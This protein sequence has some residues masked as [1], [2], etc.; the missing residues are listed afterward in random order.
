M[1][2]IK[3]ENKKALRSYLQMF[4]HQ[5]G[6]QKLHFGLPQLALDRGWA[7]YNPKEQCCDGG[8]ALPLDWNSLYSQLNLLDL[9]QAL[10]PLIYLPSSQGTLYHH[11]FSGHRQVC[12]SFWIFFQESLALPWFVTGLPALETRS[13]FD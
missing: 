13:S 3:K 8:A 12:P 9:L 11:E 2:N 1:G 6:D 5:V 7:R 4:S 10:L